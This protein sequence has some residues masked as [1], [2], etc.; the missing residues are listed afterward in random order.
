[1][2][3]H[4]LISIH[5]F[6]IL[7]KTTPRTIRFYDK[8]G[9]LKP[10]EIDKFT[11][12]RYYSPY[13][14]RDF[15]RI[16]LL[17]NFNV[18][19]AEISSRQGSDFLDERMKQ[20][21]NE[22]IEKKKEFEFLKKIK[23]YIFAEDL[24]RYLKEENIGP[25]LLM[26]EYS[27]EGR[28]DKINDDAN[29]VRLFANK[30]GIKTT[31]RNFTFYLDYTTYKPKNTRLENGIIIK[32]NIPKKLELPKNYFVRTF[33]RTRCLVL[34]YRGPFEFITLLYERLHELKIREKFKVDLPFDIFIGGP[35]T[36]ISPY[37]YRT[38]IIFPLVN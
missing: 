31:E 23:Q 6:S 33:P 20:V 2:K 8:I 3:Q 11:K 5:E 30:H 25:F 7:C 14:T 10:V 18:A 36:N 22:L 13:Q 1:M 24:F 12:Y 19:L 34:N 21:K 29:N 35:F 32:G 27:S 15:F 38:K 28:Y 9:L 16:R 17:Q 4:D 37:D 26:G